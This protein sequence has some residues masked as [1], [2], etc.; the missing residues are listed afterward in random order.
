MLWA[1]REIEWQVPPREPKTEDEPAEAIEAERTAEQDA[2]DNAEEFTDADAKELE[3]LLQL[4]FPLWTRREFQQFVKA[5]EKHGRT[6]TYA[7]IA[8]EIEGKSDKDVKAYAQVFWQR[9][10][11][12]PEYERINARIEE[13]QA[14][15][16]KESSLSQLLQRKIES[17]R[18]PMQELHLNYPTTK[19][20]IYSEEEDRYL[21]CRL[22]HYGVASDEVYERIKKDITEFPVFRFDWFFKSR[23]AVELQ[24]RCN[25]LLGMISKEADDEKVKEAS[26]KGRK[27][28]RS[29]DEAG[30]AEASRSAT[31]TTAKR[32]APKKRKMQA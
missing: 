26:G 18:Y 6:A 4:G 30:L 21:L 12:L 3:G 29:F 2:V 8:S 1:K 27:P 9:W 24:R 20:K 17:V 13:G 16:D 23:T 14:R 25:T 7:Q 22:H 32:G 31:P 5:L 28:K 11:M 10:H 19:G 15:R